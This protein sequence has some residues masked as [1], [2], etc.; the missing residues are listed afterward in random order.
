M[1]LTLEPIS[2]PVAMKTHP[3]SMK[4]HTGAVGVH[5]GAMDILSLDPW[6]LTLEKIG[7]L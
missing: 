7:S 2:H 5:D 1:G 6:R 4:P 3:G